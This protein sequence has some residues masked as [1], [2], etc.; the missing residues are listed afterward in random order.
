MIKKPHRKI[1]LTR[2]TLRI[3]SGE[4]LA[5]VAGGYTAAATCTLSDG[6]GP[7]PSRGP[8]GSTIIII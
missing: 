4:Q 2:E 7:F 3:V 1:Q 8:C 6:T 5:A